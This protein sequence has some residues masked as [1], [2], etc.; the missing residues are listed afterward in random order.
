MLIFFLIYFSLRFVLLFR[1][2][3]IKAEHYRKP[4]MCKLYSFLINFI[5]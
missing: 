2:Q 4:I 5:L 3:H 1:Y